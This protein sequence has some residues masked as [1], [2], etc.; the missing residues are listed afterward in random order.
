M[1]ELPILTSLKTRKRSFSW[2][3]RISHWKTYTLVL[4]TNQAR[5]KHNNIIKISLTYCCVRS[6]VTHWFLISAKIIQISFFGNR[7]I[8]MKLSSTLIIITYAGNWRKN[9]FIFLVW[10]Q[11]FFSFVKHWLIRCSPCYCHNLCPFLSQSIKHVEPKV[12]TLYQHLPPPTSPDLNSWQQRAQLY[13]EDL[14][15]LTL[16]LP[17]YK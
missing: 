16:K 11:F 17:Q 4:T 10:Y 9:K 8:F 6:A 14:E 13:I 1:A 2:L 7:F 3:N 15:W 5:I 12:L